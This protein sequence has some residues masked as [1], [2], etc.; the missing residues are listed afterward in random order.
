MHKTNPNPAF[1]SDLEPFHGIPTFMR[2]PASRDLEG[3]DL[4]I[5]GIP[6][7][8]GTTYRGGT[9]FG[10]RKIRES[11]LLLWGY[12]QILGVMPAEALAMVDYGDVSVVPVDIVATMGQIAEEVAGILGQGT[13]VVALGGDHS[14]TLPL[15]RA[16]AAKHGPL[17]VVHYDSHPDTWKRE[18]DGQ[19]Y[20]HGTPFRRA[21]EEGLIDT[22]AYVQVGIR[23]PTSG[24]EDLADAVEMGANTLTIG[25]VFDM[26][27]P[28]VIDEM[29]TTVG[30]R[31]VYV[32]LDIDAVDPAYAPGT[33]TPEVGGL[34]SYQI[35][36]LVRGLQGLDLVGFDLVEVSPPYDHGEITSIL[37]ANLVFEFLSLVALRMGGE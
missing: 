27:I 34:S 15:L 28:A 29:R 35:L 14:I 26:G 1:G 10:S 32:S 3:V 24:P 17:A 7:D 37:A 4:A 8:S 23:G 22:S 12:N 31:P 19:P 20:S 6:F 2:L 25:R 30:E 5:V 36:Q 11:S 16:H 13:T 18:F 9:R 21:I 33:G